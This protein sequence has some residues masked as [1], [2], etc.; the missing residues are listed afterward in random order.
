MRTTIRSIILSFTTLGITLAAAPPEPAKVTWKRTPHPRLFADQQRFS[1][2]KK[3]LQTTFAP[4]W[5]TIEK[6]ADAVRAKH[7]PAY[8]AGRDMSGEEQW[9]QMYTASDLPY[10]A[11]AYK[12]TG[13]TTYLD[14]AKEWTLASCGLPALG[15][16]VEGRR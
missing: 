4:M 8:P 6:R 7:P 12:L 11:L 14:A 10:L 3:G 9:W 16:R 1:E 2:M 15:D 5:P 13:K